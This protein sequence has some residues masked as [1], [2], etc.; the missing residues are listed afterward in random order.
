MHVGSTLF[1]ASATKTVQFTLGNLEDRF[2]ALVTG[3]I[4]S[5]KISLQTVACAYTQHRPLCVEP[6]PERPKA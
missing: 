1:R 6:V 2:F 5:I 3:Q 4:C